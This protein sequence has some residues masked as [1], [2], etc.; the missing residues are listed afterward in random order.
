MTPAERGCYVDCL[1]F[2][3]AVG[4]LPGEDLARM[5]QIMRCSVA[6]ARKLWPVIASKFAKCDDGL[7]RNARLESVRAEKQAWHDSR[8]RNG[9]KGGRP[10]KQETTRLASGFDSQNLVD[11]S[12][13]SSVATQ[14]RDA[15]AS[16]RD[17]FGFRRNPADVATALVGESQQ[18]GLPASWWERARKD[19]GLADAD[20]DRFA[21]WLAVEVRRGLVVGANKL[22]W[23]DEQLARFVAS[24]SAPA[25]SYPK[26]SD[27]LAKQQAAMD[28]AVSE[29]GRG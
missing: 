4:G 22:R 2:Q 6:D 14:Q 17:P 5:A 26:A 1:W 25:S 9:S 3:W 28:A 18:I 21:S 11:H 10:Q 15:R 13:S 29:S 24:L 8:K 20:V 16:Y 19:R 12:S 27:W 23:L 7:Y